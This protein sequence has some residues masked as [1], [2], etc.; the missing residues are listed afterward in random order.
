MYICI[1]MYVCMYSA[2]W[3]QLDTC[4]SCVSR[5]ARVVMQVLGTFLQRVNPR[6]TS[7]S[8]LHVVPVS[9]SS[10]TLIISIVH[11]SPSQQLVLCNIVI[12]NMEHSSSKTMWR[13]CDYIWH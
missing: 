6:V 13:T 5:I 12:L 9:I 2:A 7:F 1:T 3:G 4:L 10:H 11:P 8:Q